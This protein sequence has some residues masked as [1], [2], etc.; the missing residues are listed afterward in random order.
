[1]L[2]AQTVS[3]LKGISHASS[4]AYPEGGLLFTFQ[5]AYRQ[6]H[7]RLNGST[8][9]DKNNANT[10]KLSDAEFSEL[11][12]FIQVALGDYPS[13]QGFDSN[14]RISRNTV[15]TAKTLISSIKEDLNFDFIRLGIQANDYDMTATLEMVCRQSNDYFLLELW[16]S[17]D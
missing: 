17:L 14:S 9:Q 7:C 5:F 16:W 2:S 15:D 4:F 1:M 13:I 10:D 11:G 6:A 8:H 12:R 3:F